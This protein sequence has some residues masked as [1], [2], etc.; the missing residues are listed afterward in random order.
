M[1]RPI[2][3]FFIFFSR[4]VILAFLVLMILWAVLERYTS[5]PRLLARISPCSRCRLCSIIGLGVL[6]VFVVIGGWYLGLDGFAGEVEPVVSSLSWLVQNGEPLYHDFDSPQRYSVLYGPSV[7][8]TNGLFLDVL[9]PSLTSAKIA[10][11]LGVL[12]ALLFFYASLAEAGRRWVALVMTGLAAL[13]L[14]SQGFAAY[15]VRPDALLLFAIGLALYAA[16]RSSRLVALVAFAVMFGFAVNLKVHAV[17]YFIPVAAILFNRFGWWPLVASG[18]GS[19]VVIVAPFAL[20]PQV[21]AENYLAW[22]KNAMD[23]GLGNHSLA[24]TLQFSAFL[25]LPLAVLLFVAPRREA[26]V[27]KYALYLGSLVP[28][29]FLTLVLAEKPGA[30][31]VHLLPLVPS[32]LYFAGLILGDLVQGARLNPVFNGD[33]WRRSAV[34]AVALTVIFTGSVN[35]YRAVRLVDWQVDQAPD[36]SADVKGILGQFPDLTIGMACGGEDASFRNTWLR[37]LLVFADQPLL[38][39]PVSVMDCRLTGMEMPPETYQALQDG[40]VALWL[41]PR[42]EKPFSKTNW[43]APHGPLFSDRFI[44]H[45]ESLYTRRGHS[46]YFDLWLW[47]GMDQAEGGSGRFPAGGAKRQGVLSP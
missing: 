27:R 17:V 33:P 14:W 5:V 22:L 6:A 3:D 44:A 32:T 10:S 4:H 41:V 19:A 13:Y 29:F 23:Q 45:F 40:L 2:L 1:I 21:S 24:D 34:V 9:G 42:N 47:N 37:P 12:G 20:Y 35:A 46:K 31:L 18:L 28:A 26:L 16:A 8:L 11:L 7:F 25:I 43:Y 38:V 15:L 39:E 30:G 36:L